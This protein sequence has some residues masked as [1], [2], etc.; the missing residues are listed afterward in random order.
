MQ[1]ETTNLNRFLQSIVR[2]EL[3][4]HHYF[5]GQLL[6]YDKHLNI[7]IYDAEEHQ[8]TEEGENVSNQDLLIIRG[9][10]I[11]AVTMEQPP[12]A[13]SKDVRSSHIHVGIGKVHPFGRG[14]NSQ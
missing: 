5:I 8:I 13:H 4:E 11:Q 10:N 14:F 3:N 7:V 1:L 9:E 12:T 6:A 2:V